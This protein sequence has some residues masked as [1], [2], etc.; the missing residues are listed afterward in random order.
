MRSQHPVMI[1]VPFFEVSL[2][3]FT[4]VFSWKAFKELLVKIKLISILVYI[5]GNEHS[6]L[7]YYIAEQIAYRLTATNSVLRQ[8]VCSLDIRRDYAPIFRETL[9]ACSQI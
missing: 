5:T 7:I 4:K 3:A 9:K 8:F 6:R 2:V 1:R